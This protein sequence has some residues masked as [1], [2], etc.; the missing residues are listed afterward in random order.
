MSS[1]KIIEERIATLKKAL[2]QLTKYRSEGLD[3]KEYNNFLAK[4]H[5]IAF[6][7]NEKKLGLELQ[8]CPIISKEKLAEMFNSFPENIIIP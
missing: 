1:I 3:V 8:Y 2:R 7:L 4:T 5:T 6:I